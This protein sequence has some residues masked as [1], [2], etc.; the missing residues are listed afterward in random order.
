MI[1]QRSI[2]HQILNILQKNPE[3]FKIAFSKCM[4][5]TVY[6]TWDTLYYVTIIRF[7]D[8]RSSYHELNHGKCHPFAL[9]SSP[10]LLVSVRTEQLPLSLVGPA[11][12]QNTFHHHRTL[13]LTAQPN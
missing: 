2:G 4:L 11:V 5:N 8:K 9:V 1:L 10:F 3:K 7:L 12:R 6:T 13:P